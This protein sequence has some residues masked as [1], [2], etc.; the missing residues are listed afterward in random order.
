MEACVVVCRTRNPQPRRG[1]I[2]FIDAVADFEGICSAHAMVLRA[3]HEV[4]LP[5]F[6]PFVM[7]S[8]HFMERGLKIPVGSLS[9]TINW[10]ALAA[11]E[12]ALPP[13]EEQRRIVTALRA[14]RE[15]DES[16]VAATHFRNLVSLRTGLLP[17]VR[18]SGWRG[19]PNG[20]FRSPCQLGGRI[21][22]IC[23]LSRTRKILPPPPETFRSSRVEAIRSPKA[24]MLVRDAGIDLRR[25]RLCPRKTCSTAIRFRQ[26]QFSS[27]S[28]P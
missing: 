8:D 12:F 22:S 24:E 14:W 2:L 13:I 28:Q 10:K 11:E 15:L 4:V 21:A 20:G 17:V 3:K 18:S 9:P 25:L 5:E 7:Q 26:I 27:R 23:G 19:H 16:L 1:K 6:L